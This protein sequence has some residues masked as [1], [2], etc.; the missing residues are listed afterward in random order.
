MRNLNYLLLILLSLFAFSCNTNTEKETPEHHEQ[1]ISSADIQLDHGKKWLAN[2]ETTAGIKTME[3]ICSHYNGEVAQ[4]ENT[5][6]ALYSEFNLIFERCTMTGEAH[7]QLHTFLI[8]V[9]NQLG[10]L[11][12]CKSECDKEVKYLEDYL[13]TYYTYFE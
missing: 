9:K 11:K 10:I 8:P 13:A 2:P 12:D 1:T 7:E 3:N 5:Y 4:L 6:L